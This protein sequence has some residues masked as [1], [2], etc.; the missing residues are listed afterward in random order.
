MYN[1]SDKPNKNDKNDNSDD[2]GDDEG[3]DYS[4]DQRPSDITKRENDLL[5]IKV[6]N[7]LLKD[8]RAQMKLQA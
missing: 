3:D 6:Q 8:V 7:Q 1:D 4:N 5:E 2:E